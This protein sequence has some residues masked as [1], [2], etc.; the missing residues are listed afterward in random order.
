MPN[1][2]DSITIKADISK[3]GWIIDKPVITRSGVFVY[4]DN[5]GKF[6]KEYR[7]EEEVF[8]AESL[9]TLRGIPITDG[10]KGILSS[11]SSLD[12]IIVGSVM[13]PGEKADN[14]VVADIV[15]HNVKKI[16]TKREL[17]L[18]YQCKVEETPGEFNGEKYDSI[19]TNIVYNH[20]AVVNKGR[21]G[22]ARIRLDADDLS[23]F[24]TEDNTMD[25]VLQ[26]IRLDTGLE[27]S[28]SP[29][30]IVYVSDLNAKLTALQTK[31]D[32]AEG[33]RDTH[34]S[35]IE[36]LKA[37]HVKE[38]AKMT[39][40]ARSRVKLEEKAKLL[41]VKFDDVSDR[42]LKIAIAEKLGAKLEW[43][44]RSDDYVDSAYDL[45]IANEAK[46]NETAGKQ[47]TTTTDKADSKSSTSSQDA[48]ARMISR[49]RG[50]KQ[51]AA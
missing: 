38:L 18:G 50:E 13:S 24:P 51:E 25:P 23:S 46:K 15:I 47:K 28:A 12:N 10:H 16:G 1:R 20:L 27:Y 37:D 11:E 44:D 8:K 4:R 40:G 45:T 9:N 32:K 33:E 41:A 22:N 19:Q 31:L 30:V 35:A 36:T 6:V 43:K 5:K 2:Y 26:K 48:R 17:S 42:D 14:N 7:P 21:A 49:L 3:D 39:D 34:K 29:E